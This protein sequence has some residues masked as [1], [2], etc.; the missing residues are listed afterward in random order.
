[1]T[2]SDVKTLCGELIRGELELYKGEAERVAIQ[3]E[4]RLFSNIVEELKKE[5]IT[6]GEICNEFKSPDM[7]Y[8][9]VEAQKAFIRDGSENAERVLTNLIIKRVKEQDKS[10][11]KITLD[12]AITV[13]PK[14]LPEQLDT[15]ALCFVLRRTRFNTVNNM[16]TFFDFLRNTVLPLVKRSSLTEASLM[17]LV[18]TGAGVMETGQISIEE[19]LA[20]TYGGLFMKGNSLEELK[21]YNERFPMMFTK[22]LRDNGKYQVNSISLE[23]LEKTLNKYKNATRDDIE[24]IK[25][26]F[27]SGIVSPEEIRKMI[28]KDCSE[29]K[30]LFEI[31]NG[32]RIKH[33][34]LTSVGVVLGAIRLKQNTNIEFDLHT[35]I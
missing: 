16:L 31:W 5:K 26:L 35:W 29:M 30:E 1:M 25:H 21:G 12:E 2:Y 11:L 28:C 19:L 4:E 33:F 3:R 10:L 22:C 8:A 6:D 34:G 24:F 18:Y 9:Y 23:E 27:V 14:I 7:Q 20:N 17:H 32:T 13:V 15:L